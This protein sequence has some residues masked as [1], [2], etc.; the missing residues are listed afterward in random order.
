MLI[1]GYGISFWGDEDVLILVLI[2]D[3]QLCEYTK[4]T[5]LYTLKGWIL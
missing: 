4:I 2:M 3:A 5:D 1:N